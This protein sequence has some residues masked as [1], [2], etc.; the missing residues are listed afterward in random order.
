[1]RG[2]LLVLGTTCDFLGS[3]CTVL[4]YV[5]VHVV[6]NNHHQFPWFCGDLSARGRGEQY[7]GMIRKIRS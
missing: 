6:D 7:K 4:Y 3:T 1:M 2:S 5:H